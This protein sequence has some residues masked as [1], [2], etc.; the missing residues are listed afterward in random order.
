M[1]P[2]LLPAFFSYVVVIGF[3]LVVEE[4]C[5]GSPSF[6]RSRDGM[7]D[8]LELVREKATLVGLAVAEVS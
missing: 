4:V 1:L 7:L 5:L 8:T 3:G 2:N 6:S